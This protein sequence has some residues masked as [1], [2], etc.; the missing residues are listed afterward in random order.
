MNIW[1]KKTFKFPHQCGLIYCLFYGGK[2][3][4]IGSLFVVTLSVC[5]DRRVFVFGP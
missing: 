2:Y 1:G 5:G 4:D 3:I